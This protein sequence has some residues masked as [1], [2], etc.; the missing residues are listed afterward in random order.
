MNKLPCFLKAFA[1]ILGLDTGWNCDISLATDN[2]NRQFPRSY[3]ESYRGAEI[4][5]DE[6]KSKS[7]K[8]LD[9]NKPTR[10][11]VK[12]TANQR[13]SK[14]A[15]AFLKPL[16]SKFKKFNA[17][18]LR[19][20][21]A[22]KTVY[23]SL[24]S[25]KFAMSKSKL[26]NGENT[27]LNMNSSQIVKFDLRNVNKD[28]L[29][30]EDAMNE[31]TCQSPT[32]KNRKLSSQSSI[33]SE[34]ARNGRS[35]KIS[36]N[37]SS[38]AVLSA[39]KSKLGSTS[40]AKQADAKRA[41]ELNVSKLSVSSSKSSFRHMNKQL[42]KNKKKRKSV[43]ESSSHRTVYSSRTLS[44]TEVLENAVSWEWR[45]LWFQEVLSVTPSF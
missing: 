22:K 39:L 36:S 29:E 42:R 13:N 38:L 37:S 31:I 24:P 7:S 43:D 17:N 2:D 21:S 1:E 14:R 25:L 41:N 40:A 27:V 44:E 9:M 4:V 32:V 8:S 23:Q 3:D 28:S 35:K 18:Y 45:R 30:E 34:E 16:N 33:Q 15:A 5:Q 10:S 12:L 6:F 11:R 20:S 26:E 19:L